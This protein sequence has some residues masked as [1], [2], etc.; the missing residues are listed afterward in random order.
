[1]SPGT[2]S[3]AGCWYAACLYAAG[4]GWAVV[5]DVAQPGTIPGGPGLYQQEAAPGAYATHELA[6]A[7][8][9]QLNRPALL[10]LRPADRYGELPPP[11]DDY[12]PHPWDLQEPL[13][14]YS[15]A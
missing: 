9:E 1:M 8:A 5:R 14:V 15:H 11:A 13:P 12:H 3:Q 10:R 2:T 6:Q 4:P 7:A